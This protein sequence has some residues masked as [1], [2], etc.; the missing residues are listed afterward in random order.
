MDGDLLIDPM[1]RTWVILP[2]MLI[3]FLFYL[4]RHYAS[5]YLT[6]RTIDLKKIAEGYA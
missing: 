5:Q 4:G 1:I 2:I 6:T 3:A